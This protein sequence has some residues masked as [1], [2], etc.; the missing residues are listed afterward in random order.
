MPDISADKII[1]AGATAFRAVVPAQEVL[2]VVQS[3]TTSVDRVFY[4]VTGLSVAT[5]LFAFGLGWKDI[6]Q[7]PKAVTTPTQTANVSR[8]EEKQ[9]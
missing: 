9:V 1:T 5:V 8:D 3:Y 2:G 4:L 6:R 7:S